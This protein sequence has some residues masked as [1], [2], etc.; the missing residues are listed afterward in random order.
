ML[1]AYNCL[2]NEHDLRLVSLAGLVCILASFS[3]INL[4]HH[5][6]RTEGRMRTVWLWVAAIATGFGIWATH[7][8]AM[9]A[10]SPAMPTEYH[11]VLT[12]VSLLAAIL[13]ARLGLSA[14][15]AEIRFA[16]WRGGAV[17][18]GGIAVVHYTGMAAF[19]IPGRVEWNPL[20][21]VFSIALGT[22]AAA[23][24]R[25][26]TRSHK[27]SIHRRDLAAGCCNH[28]PS[29]HGYGCGHDHA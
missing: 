16:R 6:L 19:E 22:T 24:V 4:L 25:R 23:L 17:V 21:A 29:L 26:T 11:V 10:F 27:D 12:S 13:F 15:L 9:L 5:V 14:A 18:G 20:L 3:A 2:V 28:R 8:I 1:T 7:F